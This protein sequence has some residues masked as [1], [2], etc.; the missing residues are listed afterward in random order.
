[1]LEL[2]ISDVVMTGLVGETVEIVSTALDSGPEAGGALIGIDTRLTVVEH[3]SLVE[4]LCL[5]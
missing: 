3:P 1:M 2:E 5:S 4:N